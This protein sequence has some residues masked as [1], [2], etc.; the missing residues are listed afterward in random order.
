MYKNLDRLNSKDDLCSAFMNLLK[1]FFEHDSLA[2]QAQLLMYCCSIY[3]LNCT[4][5]IRFMYNHCLKYLSD[6]SLQ[7]YYNAINKEQ[8]QDYWRETLIKIAISAIPECL[9]DLPIYLIIDDTL[10][11]KIGQHFE[12]ISILHDHCARNGTSYLSGHCYVSIILAIP[13]LINGNIRYIRIPIEHKLWIPKNQRKNVKNDKKNNDDN[14]KN[15]QY[16]IFSDDDNKLELANKLID[17]VVKL[18]GTDHKFILFADAWYAK[19]PI[20]DLIHRSDLKIAMVCGVR[21]D[22]KLYYLPPEYKGR[23]RKPIYGDVIK[24]DKLH[25]VKMP[26]SPYKIAYTK[27]KARIFGDQEVSI[28]VTKEQNGKPRVFIC[29]DPTF[30][31]GLDPSILPNVDKN[32]AKFLTLNPQF[33]PLVAY[34]YRWMVEVVYQEQKASWGLEDY[35]LKSQ[36]GFTTLVTLHSILYALT[37]LLPFLDQ[38][39]AGCVNLSIQDRR[40]WLGQALNIK[41]ILATFV[42][43]C[44]NAQN[45]EDI[46]NIY[47]NMSLTDIIAM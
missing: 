17:N 4:K 40:G 35:R 14:S 41:L 47:N 22:A 15:T 34:R 20:T 44:E 3:M 37:S 28:F 1:P 5:P 11:E 38:K 39:F 25:Y 26:G 2:V 9:R 24:I 36:N 46:V 30:F 21:F 27:G 23:G 8:Y 31:A 45:H 32:L 18:I 29:T 42:D 33:I 19:A 13:V 16:Q 6:I 43:L 10:I 12:H 7:N